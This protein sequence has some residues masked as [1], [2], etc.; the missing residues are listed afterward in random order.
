[1]FARQVFRQKCSYADGLSDN[2]RIQVAYRVQ[3]RRR[4]VRYKCGFA[5]RYEH[6]VTCPR[7]GTVGPESLRNRMGLMTLVRM[8]RFGRWPELRSDPM[9]PVNYGQQQGLRRQRLEFRFSEMAH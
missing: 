5:N 3:A 2:T 7:L 8:R 1:M 6:F 4:F 9:N